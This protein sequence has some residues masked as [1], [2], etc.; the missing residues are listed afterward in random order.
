MLTE[1]KVKTARLDEKATL[2]VLG[3][4]P[5]NKLSR[6]VLFKV[7][8]HLLLVLGFEH[9]DV[10][11]QFILSTSKTYLCLEFEKRKLHFNLQ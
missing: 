6:T 9:S 1:F 3:F 10:N 8:S 2:P 4:V 7:A 5:I 11:A